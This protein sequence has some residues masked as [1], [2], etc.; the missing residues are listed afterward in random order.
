MST[1][2][3]GA[4]TLLITAALLGGCEMGLPLGGPVD[5]G[6]CPSDEM[7]FE[8][9]VWAEVLGPTCQDCHSPDGLARGTDFVL[10]YGTETGWLRENYE[11][12]KALSVIPEGDS[13]LPLSLMKPTGLHSD[14]H[15]GGALISPDSRAYELLATMV[16]RFNGQL[17]D[18]NEGTHLELDCDEDTDIKPGPRLLR[19]LS[20][21]EYDATAVDLLAISASPGEAF[22]PDNVILGY[23]NN[24]EALAV[25]SLLADQ[26]RTSAEDLAE[27]VVANHLSAIL[28]CDPAALGESTCAES[29]IVEFGARA[30]RRPL[31][32]AD[33]DRYLQLWDQVA[34]E[35]GFD[36]GVQWVITAMLQSP[37]YLYR[38]ELGAHAGDGRFVL[39][40]W[41]VAAELSYLIWGTMPDAELFAEAAAGE[42]SDPVARTARAE[43]MLDDPRA[44]QTMGRFSERWLQYTRLKT[45]TRDAE[46]FPEFTPAIRTAMLG[47]TE[48]LIRD[49]FVTSSTLEELFVGVSS[50]MTDELAAYYDVAPG[51]GPA[52]A[53][54]FRAV[55][56]ENSERVGLLSQGS[57]LTS[58]ALPTSSSPIHRGLL[59]RERLL[60]QQLPPPPPNVDASPPEMDPTLSTRERYEAH[61]TVEECASC[62][63]LIDP[64]GFSFEHF[65]A[66]G[67][68]RAMEG[69]HSID[70]SGEI[71]G[72]ADT[73]A[74]FDGLSEA[75][76]LLANSPDVES[77][78]VRQWMRFGFGLEEQKDLRCEAERLSEAF[79][80]GGAHLDD[81]LPALVAS[82]HFGEREGD[83]AELDGAAS[84]PFDDPVVPGDDDDSVGDDDDTVGDDDDSVGDDDDTVGDDDDSV[85]DVAFTLV[86][87]NDWGAGYCADI[88]VENL[89]PADL[90]WQIEAEIE[91]T[92]NSLW[93][94]VDTPTTGNWV[95]FVGVS[96]N[97]T[98]PPGQTTSFGFCADR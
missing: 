71:I 56:I 96:W 70:T 48:R 81:V 67:R 73:D 35:D 64:I 9:R 34:A 7:Y 97:A 59:V 86:V 12:F 24:A 26:Y 94:A 82:I 76:T 90:T 57:I 95:Q 38:S 18:C 63:S 29:F 32:P 84:G 55:S 16:G 89:S 51:T 50:P 14:G 27:E 21:A 54:G 4:G 20:H 75:S 88:V 45:V 37:H 62:H 8:H 28:G 13:S 79:V 87:Q 10:V 49:A 80:A 91:G 6:D 3:R 1:L 17:D 31:T 53:E 30:F 43:S 19:R 41:E 69:P 42:L 98:I 40:D 60:C 36:V 61:T 46:L 58:R 25:S 72:T 5:I 68:W 15:G 77:C 85:S 33:V 22:A 93:N 23:D 66:V 39:S 74:V 11:S 92:M 83:P 44:A 52:D 78:Y 65:D 47:E 2:I